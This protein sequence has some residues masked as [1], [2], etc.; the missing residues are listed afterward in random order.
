MNIRLMKEGFDYKII[1]DDLN[2]VKE[3]LQT[4]ETVEEVTYIVPENN[5]P[6]LE[7][8]LPNG[9]EILTIRDDW[10]TQIYFSPG[11]FKKAVPDVEYSIFQT[12]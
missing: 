2:K 12:K 7:Y 8:R 9:E 5:T 3:I 11:N 4:A 10:G 6:V 1:G